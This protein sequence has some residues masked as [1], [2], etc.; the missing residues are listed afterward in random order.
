M[1]FGVLGAAGQL[2]SE[3][4]SLLSG[5]VV[6]LAR[7]ELDLSRSDQIPAV[8]AALG[9]DVLVNCA[10]YNFV[11]RAETEPEAAFAVNAWGVRILARACHQARVRLVHFSTDYVFGLDRD[12]TMPYTETDL[13]GPLNVYGLSKLAGEYLARAECPGALIIRTC[14]LYGSRGRGGKGGNFATTMLRLAREGAPIQV[15]DDQRCTP[16]Y[17]LHVARATAVLIEAGVEGIYHVTNSGCCT[18]YEFARH[19]FELRGLKP[20]LTP[21]RS[22]G[23]ERIANRPSYSVLSSQKL[24]SLGLISMPNWRDALATYF[25]D[26]ECTPV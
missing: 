10:A 14:G 21:I 9:L 25:L 6:P 15:V 20:N 13:P 7:S 1:R 4:I 19:L 5:E 18:W 8:V 2:G 22:K 26:S 3:L 16:S 12:R 23:L 24:A 17:T 11:D